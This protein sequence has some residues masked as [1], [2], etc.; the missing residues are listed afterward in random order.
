[1]SFLLVPMFCVS[2]GFVAFL[3]ASW[4]LSYIRIRTSHGGF[5]SR[6]ERKAARVMGLAVGLGFAAVFAVGDVV[7]GTAGV[8]VSAGVDAVI[9][10]VGLGWVWRILT[11]RASRRRS[12]TAGR[13]ASSTEGR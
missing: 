13:Q 6:R 3:G 5:S 4:L 10:L 2:V 7:S 9:L 1:M 8:M 11:G 12:K